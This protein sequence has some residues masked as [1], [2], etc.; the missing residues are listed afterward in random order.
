MISLSKKLGITKDELKDK[1]EKLY[2]S[3]LSQKKI[4]QEIGCHTS[5]VEKLFKTLKIKSRTLSQSFRLIKEKHINITEEEMEIINGLI[6]S[7]FHIEKSKFQA[8]FAFTLLH[9]E[10]AEKIISELSSIKWGNLYELKSLRTPNINYCGKSQSAV[11]IRYL[12]E[13][14]YKNNKKIVPKDLVLSPRVLY[15]WY[16]GDGFITKN[17]NR[18][19][20]CTDAF[21]KKDNLFLIKKLKEIKLL[22][23]LTKRNRI[24]FN[25]EN[26]EK[27]LNYIG[28]NTIECYQY[29]WTGLGII[30]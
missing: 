17:K 10:F 7:D 1:I 6:L 9:K 14:W 19:E 12:R 18:I 5:T 4:S 24:K 3:G 29:K 28:Y 23:S 30:K 8:R 21:S 20:L 22:G 27:F 16:L 26:V 2:S 13:K 15:W 25:K 11:E